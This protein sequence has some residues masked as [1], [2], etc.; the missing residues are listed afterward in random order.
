MNFYYSFFSIFFFSTFFHPG[1]QKCTNNVNHHVQT[2]LVMVRFF[3][4]MVRFFKMILVV[5]ETERMCKMEKSSKLYETLW[6]CCLANAD[7]VFDFEVFK[8][9]AVIIK[10]VKM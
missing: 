3:K 7:E 4:M 6:N 9:A 1:S 5:M 2:L 8:L 10:A